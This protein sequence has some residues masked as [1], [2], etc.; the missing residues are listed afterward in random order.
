MTEAGNKYAEAMGCDEHT[1]YQQIME[2]ARDIVLVVAEDGGIMNANQAA[3]N[4]YGYSLNELR[5]IRVH[6]LRSPEPRILVEAQIKRA[7][8]EG[9]LF[10]TI[11]VRR[12]GERFP[13]EVSSH[14]VQV[15]AG[16]AVVSVIRD[17]TE[18]VSKETELRQK[19][20]ILTSLHETAIG[21]MQSLD[22]DNVLAAIVS[23]AT[24]LIGTA[25]GFINILNEEQGVFE[26]KVGLGYY[27]QDIGRKTR[28][29]EGF[30]GQ[31]Y[32]SGEIMVV[33]DYRSSKSRLNGAFFDRVCKVILVP[34]KQETKVIGVFGLSFLES[35]RSFSEHEISLLAQFA[36]LASIAL[37]NARLHSSLSESEKK[38][39]K[40]NGDITAMYEELLASDEELRQQ[41]DELLTK[42]EAIRRQTAIL[43]ALHDTAMGLMHRHEPE[44]LLQQI[45][46]GAS[47]LVGTPH[48]FIY[49]LD[50]QKKVFRRSH[51]SGIFAQ[52]INRERSVDQGI[53]GEAYQTGAPVIVNDYQEW[54]RRRLEL[55]RFKAVSS[56]V[57]IPLQSDGQVIGIIG[58]AY[59][60]EDKGFGSNEVE[61]LSQFAELASIA[62]GNA[63]LVQ[64][65]RRMAYYDSLT[66]LPNRAY[67][68]EHLG[69]ELEKARRGEATG[70]VLFID[71]DD[72][73]V[74]NDTLGHSCGD[75][76]I[77]K[78]GANILAAVG[79]H[80][81]VAR[82]GGDEFIV[83]FSGESDR[84]KVAFIADDLVKLLSRDYEIAGSRI[85]LSASIGIALY[86]SDADT[87]EDIFKNAD[88]ALYAA[89][90]SGKNT[91]RFY[92]DNLQTVAYDNMMLKRG[93]REAIE[94]EELSLYYQPLVDT[95]SGCVVSFEAL[96]RWTNPAY[97][98]VPPSRF[99]PL[100][101]ESDTIQKIGKWVIEEACRF[102]RKLAELGQGNIRVSVNVSPRQLVADDF[103]AVVCK[104]IET[105]SIEPGQME[106]EITENVLIDS[107]EASINKLRE[108]RAVGV[109][110]LLDDFGT[111]YSS[112]TYLR[113]LP[114]GILKIDKSFIDLIASDAAQLQFI[115]SIVNM[116]HVLHLTVVA[117][118]VESEEQVNALKKCRCDY[119][120]GYFY[121][122]PVPEKNAILYI[123][124]H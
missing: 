104:A 29:T 1:I 15:M 109:G 19:N 36:E 32:H 14:R 124:T 94:R 27:T 16:E 73:K 92:K 6:D 40:N 26:R 72:F 48:A 65:M 67:L 60:E 120:Q 7:Q 114:V 103:V 3:I 85:H 71:M 12:N 99:I 23:H 123:T 57:E 37:V 115:S 91:W 108:L 46:A 43:K 111:G 8:Q 33:D 74:V 82:I 69:Y 54:Y 45:V 79:E 121:S 64:T 90:G 86:P 77:V 5:S 55:A 100:A 56:I 110:L 51:G 70:A 44:D 106:I 83:L 105:A 75:S 122:R 102:A 28:F 58:L 52:D 97:G 76:V 89:K 11:H 68:Q 116:A 118:G 22:L 98:V 59:C 62:L 17:I 41:F 13:V 93:L 61:V 113:H 4:A 112:L 87:A 63:F 18:A 30:G 78:A 117:E 96:L 80:S 21:L 39:Q 31:I 34:L 42:E 81:V 119:I 50:K 95:C 53:V 10:R 35:S 2:Q 9:V 47:E 20:G 49:R 25:H 88:L 66:G 38:L 107:L 84:E 101:E 24:D